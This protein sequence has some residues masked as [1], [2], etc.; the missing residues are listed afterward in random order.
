M[1]GTPAYSRS[2]RSN[3]PVKAGSC[4]ASRQATVSSSRA[5]I[6]A[7]GIM[8]P[9][10]RPKRPSDWR[11]GIDGADMRWGSSVALSQ[12]RVGP[13]GDEVGDRGAGVGP[14]DQG[15]A[16]QDDVRALLGVLE[17]VVRSADA[18]L[19]DPDD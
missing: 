7:S 12:G 19:G 11:S 15:L 18:G 13:R 4:M 10:N 2:S 6:S 9:P 14:L 16:H 1:L 5:A 17:H 8:R 3:S